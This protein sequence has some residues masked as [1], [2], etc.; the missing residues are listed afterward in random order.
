MTK[1]RPD[2]VTFNTAPFHSS[3]LPVPLKFAPPYAD[4]ATH[5]DGFAY[6][7]Q[8]MQA[9][10]D[11]P[12]PHAF[13][14]LRIDRHEDREP[15]ERYVSLCEELADSTLLSHNGRVSIGVVDGVTTT[16][17]DMPSTEAMR[18]MSVLFRQF[19]SDAELG[20]YSAVRKIIG[21]YSHDQQDDERDQRMELQRS[22][23]RARGLL[24]ARLLKTMADR[25]ALDIISGGQNTMPLPGDEVKPLEL[26]STFQYGDLIHWGEKR[27][28]LETL[29]G[30]DVDFK[31]RTH[32]FAE[33][34]IQ[35]SH[36]YL[37]YSLIVARTLD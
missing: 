18:G 17:I 33:S 27:H 12:N 3:L 36:F 19:H 6:W 8:L 37:G 10:F 11:L 22:W 21:R 16:S 31:F 26:I 23:N 2:A 7:W 25:K 28:L 20:G 14:R 5:P 30:D 32:Y 4:R 29:K 1:S 13:P 34:M 15:L 35:L 9:V 24:N